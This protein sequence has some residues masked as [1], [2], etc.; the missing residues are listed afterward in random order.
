MILKFSFVSKQKK[1]FKKNEKN[2]FQD[3]FPVFR[4]EHL[5]RKNMF[6]DF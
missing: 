2:I 5:I 6:E 3:D 1:I 4:N